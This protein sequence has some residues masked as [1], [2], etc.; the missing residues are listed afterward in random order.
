MPPN[1]T[2]AALP[3]LVRPIFNSG[4]PVSPARVT[5][6]FHSRMQSSKKRGKP[7]S[8]AA[9]APVN[10]A[11]VEYITERNSKRDRLPDIPFHRLW[12]PA[13]AGELTFVG[14][15]VVAKQD[16]LIASNGTE[17]L[18]LPITPEQRQYLAQHQRGITLTI[19]PAVTIQAQV[20]GLER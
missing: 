13:D 9:P 15:R 4:L 3:P 2:K 5:W 14:L 17:N 20:Q 6:R 18:I 1:G 12:Q 19:S 16:L 10:K 8:A 11:A 7:P